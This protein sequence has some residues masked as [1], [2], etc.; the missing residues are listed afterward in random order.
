MKALHI[1]SHTHWD[2]EWYLTFQ[3]FRFRLVRLV[4]QLLGLLERDP[5]YQ[6]FTLDGQT[7]ILDD[8]LEIRPEQEARIHQLVREGR[9]LIGPWYVLPDE[10]LEGPEAL[11][12]NL[13]FGHRGCRRAASTR[14]SMERIGY[15]P[16]SFG[17]IS[18]LPQLAAG[19]GWEAMCLWRGVGDAPTEFHWVAPDGT[20]CL[21]LHLRHGYGNGAHLPSDAESFLR[22]LAAERDA[23][24][25]HAATSHLLVMQGTD[26]MEP[27]PDLL[28]LLR[29]ADE[30]LE[31]QVIHSTLPAYLAAVQGELG[32]DGLEA[33]PRVHGELR[34]PERA[35]LLP[36]V[37]SARIWI[38]QWNARCESLLTCWA[39]PFSALAEQIGRAQDLRGFL[40]AAWRWLL[41]NHAHD[42]ICG[43]SVDQVHREM[44]SRFAWTEQLAEQ[45]TQASLETLAQHITPH[46]SESEARGG[47]RVIVFNPAAFPRTD[48]VRVRLP[49]TPA[50]DW[51]LVD[52]SGAATPYRVLGRITREPFQAQMDREAL[53]DWLGQIAAGQGPSLG[54]LVFQHLD[55]HVDDDGVAHLDVV[56]GPKPPAGDV[57]QAQQDALGRVLALLTD[58]H[59]Q[60]YRVRVIEDAG[61]EIEFLACDVPSLGY[62]QLSIQADLEA[63]NRHA[64]DTEQ[65]PESGPNDTSPTPDSGYHRIENEFFTVQAEPADGTLTVTDRGTGLVLQGVNRFVD[66]GDR[67]DEYTYC[68]PE[69][70]R[71]MNAPAAPPSIR[72]VDDGLGSSLEIHAV[73]RVPRSLDV[74]TRSARS[75]DL[76]DLPITSHVCLTPG[77]RRIEFETRVVNSAQ[78]HR[79]RVHVP[80][81]IVTDRS[82]AEGHFDVVE[83]PMALPTETEGWAEQPTGAHPQRTFVD[84]TDG[85]HGLLLANQ[86]LPEYEVLPGT[87]EAPGVTLALTLLRC[88]GWLSRGDLHN[89]SGHAGPLVPTPEAQC[90]GEHTFHYAL[91]P[92]AGNY[93]SAFR[94]AHA[95]NAPLRAVC[96]DAHAGSLPAR[97]SFLEVLPAAVVV[98]AVKPPEEGK[99]LIVRL[100]NS[101]PV[102]VEAQLTLWQPVREAALVRLDEGTPIRRLAADSDTITLPLRAKEIATLQIQFAPSG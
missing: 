52:A 56:M 10:F 49:F 81:P 98:S 87:A 83:R 99:G 11:I 31:D 36:A 5:G 77:V 19:F 27:R 32:A 43:C 92:H 22:D 75:T 13:F 30:A 9:L 29:A 17:H 15:L 34:S 3:E 38:K 51:S 60:Q 48:R 47:T 68:P 90:P 64:P 4:D 23:L 37:L 58:P 40:R 73:Y 89:R 79:L 97:G 20:P 74:E 6:F 46:D 69:Q 59:I 62:G 18:Q 24:G 12:R 66:G 45:V 16:D 84:V 8:Y 25:P 96:T 61:L 39:E 54:P 101:A 53:T 70:D 44:Q 102:P 41:Q 93:L 82:W 72:R 21:V 76:V 26:H 57:E 67:G 80:T 55:L 33:L 28:P 50:G 95:F 78:D 86:G 1:V 63:A 65:A 85:Q 35:H 7:I 88:V 2:R 94:E 14:Q 71:V 42:S 91:V 100:Y